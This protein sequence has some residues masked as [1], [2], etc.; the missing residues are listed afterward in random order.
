[1]LSRS[2]L[3]LRGAGP[4]KTPGEQLW[5]PGSLKSLLA[6]ARHPP[7]PVSRA[8][9]SSLP[10]ESELAST[11][12]PEPRAGSGTWISE[13]CWNSPSL[14]THPKARPAS[15]VPAGQGRARARDGSGAAGTAVPWPQLRA[16][17]VPREDGAAKWFPKVLSHQPGAGKSPARNFPVPSILQERLRFLKAAGPGGRDWAAGCFPSHFPA[18]SRGKAPAPH[19]EPAQVGE[20]GWGAHTALKSR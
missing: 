19:P 9:R 4:P 12:P 3:S 6:E 16:R 15:P 10:R 20:R 8:A 17:S 18:G 7:L 2:P 14:P 11:P 5:D 13:S 1:M